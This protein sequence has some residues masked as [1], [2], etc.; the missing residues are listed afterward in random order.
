MEDTLFVRNTGSVTQPPILDWLSESTMQ[1]SAAN[2]YTP[3]Y[4]IHCILQ[5][6]RDR[7]TVTD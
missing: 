1:S 7:V 3:I 4:N 2:L 6:V 5:K